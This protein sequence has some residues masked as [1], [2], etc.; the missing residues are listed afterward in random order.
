MTMHAPVLVQ[1]FT[2]LV[3]ASRSLPP[4]I[5]NFPRIS[6]LLGKIAHK[7]KNTKHTGK[8]SKAEQTSVSTKSNGFPSPSRVKLLTLLGRSRLSL[9]PANLQPHK[10]LG[11]GGLC[12]CRCCFLV[13]S[14]V[15]LKQNSSRLFQNCVNV[16][17]TIDT[18]LKRKSSFPLR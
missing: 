15:C 14:D 1:Q 16:Q 11:S 9:L 6:Y 13:R 3:C 2:H 7:K 8:E 10:L 12:L 4:L 18:G 5:E 17:E